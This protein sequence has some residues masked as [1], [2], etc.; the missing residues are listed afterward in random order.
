M[1]S[2][3]PSTNSIASNTNGDSISPSKN[4]S[5]SNNNRKSK[6]TNEPPQIQESHSNSSHADTST[7]NDSL[8]MET[9]DIESDQISPIAKKSSKKSKVNNDVKSCR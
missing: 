5:R 4:R 2:R 3:Q 7:L 6:S 1:N 9:N 8:P